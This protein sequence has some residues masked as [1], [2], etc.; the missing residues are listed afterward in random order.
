MPRTNARAWPKI[1][2]PERILEPQLVSADYRQPPVVSREEWIIPGI[3]N[4]P[5]AMDPSTLPAPYIHHN[6]TAYASP[7]SQIAAAHHQ[8]IPP[9]WLQLTHYN[10]DMSQYASPDTHLTHQYPP[11]TGINYPSNSSLPHPQ[12]AADYIYPECHKQELWVDGPT[13]FTKNLQTLTSNLHRDDVMSPS[14]RT[15]HHHTG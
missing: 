6:Q 14:H 1:S 2:T 15:H 5:T 13:E 11:V 8:P 3:S 12:T 10:G 4:P 9:P 7:I